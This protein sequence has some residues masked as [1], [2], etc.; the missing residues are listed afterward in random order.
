M[1]RSA[2][3][4]AKG[5]KPGVRTDEGKSD[6]IEPVGSTV[7][8]SQTVTRQHSREPSWIERTFSPATLIIWV[9]AFIVITL[10]ASFFMADESGTVTGETLIRAS[11]I[12][13]VAAGAL[14]G[15]LR[16]QQ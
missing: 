8:R 7:I 16:N 1:D 4:P 10:I 5:T 2:S 6:R 12:G 15:W 3:S 9:P 13:F 11:V 14:T